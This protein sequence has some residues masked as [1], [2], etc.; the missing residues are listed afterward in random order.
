[1]APDRD[2]P[3]VDEH[4][5]LVRA[6]APAVWRSLA[7][8]LTRSRMGSG[9]LAHLLAAQPRRAEGT[10]FE[11][12]ASVPGFKVCEALPA[13][14]VRLTGHHRFSRY[15]LTL[16]LI[17]RPEGTM[18]SARTDA[19]FPGLRGRLY[20]GLVIGSGAHTILMKRLLQAVRRRAEA[21]GGQSPAGSR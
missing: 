3:F 10:L 14:N 21:S 1:M 16:T 18:L 9:A 15:A 5:V 7:A 6:P 19:E 17:G 13:Q 12:G 4:Q 11:E 8:Q 2:L 20:R